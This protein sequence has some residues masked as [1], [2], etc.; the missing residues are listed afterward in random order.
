[1]P[2]FLLG[3]FKG[4]NLPLTILVLALVATLGLSR[5]VVAQRDSARALAETRQK[6]I[7]GLNLRVRNDR[8]LIN[9]RDALIGAQNA[10]IEAISKQRAEDRVIYLRN[11]AAADERAKDNDNRAAQIMD[12]PT[13]AVDELAQCRASRILLEEELTQ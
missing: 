9:Q 7:D 2:I 3:L 1:M 6:A 11:F 13:A 5:I 8:I 10:G 4:R 12:L